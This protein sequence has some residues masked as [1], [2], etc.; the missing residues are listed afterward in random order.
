MA[1]PTEV[2][3]SETPEESNVIKELRAKAKRVEEAEAKAADLERKFA[4]SEAG[5]SG[6]NDK[7]VR[8]LLSAH[9]GDIVADALKATASELGFVAAASQPQGES[10]PD[11]EAQAVA[12]EV[13]E[14]STLT[15]Q[16]SV[17]PTAP[18]SAAELEAKIKSFASPEA[19]E[20]FVLENPH[21][22]G[23]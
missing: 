12:A 6:L 19:L 5:L 9:D 3:Q 11:V 2:E 1:D 10:N 4:L 22:F 23:Q 16:P 8:A 14:L 18:R 17:D 20:A 21:L 13:S 7:Q 15:S